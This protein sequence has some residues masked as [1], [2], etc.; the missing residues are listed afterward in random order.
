MKQMGKRLLAGAVAL[1]VV[2]GCAFG[3]WKVYQ[4][5]H[6]GVVN[7]YSMEELVTTNWGDETQTEGVVSTDK[8]QTEFLS[9]TQKVEKIQVKKGQKVK[10]GD[11]LFTYDSTLSAIDLK[12]KQIELQKKQ[13]E[14][15]EA[16]KQLK[17]I[18]TYRAGVPI[19]GSKHS[20]SGGG[21]GSSRRKSRKD[22]K[23]EI[24]TYEGL[25][26]VTGNGKEKTPFSYLWKDGFQF[27]DDLLAAAMRDKVD[28][29]VRFYLGGDDI[30][31]PDPDDLNPD[32]QPDPESDDQKP[33]D[34]DKDKD[35]E[36]DTDPKEDDSGAEEPKQEEPK[37]E[38]PKQGDASDPDAPS[39]EPESQSDESRDNAPEASQLAA[40]VTV[41]TLQQLTMSVPGEEEE[42]DPAD[43]SEV[44]PGEGAGSS[45][46]G[47]ASGSASETDP[48]DQ[49]EVDPGEG[50]A[51]S[52]SGSASGSGSQAD[53]ADGELSY[54]ASWT[55][56][57][58]HTVNGYRYVM[59][60]MNVG[61]V[62]R[63]VSEPLPKMTKEENPEKQKS[64]DAWDDF[65]GGDDGGDPG[66]I[67][68]AAEIEAM[69]REQQTILRDGDL[70]LRQ[71]KLE[72]QKLDRELNNSAVYSSLNGVVTELND[73][74]NL[75]SGTPLLKVSSGGGYLVKGTISELALTSVKPGQ[76]VTINDWNTDQTYEGTVKQISEYPSPQG[77]YWSGGNS[78]VSYYPFTVTVDESANLEPNGYVEMSYNS[79]GTGSSNFYLQNS[80]IRTENGKSYVYV[81]NSGKLEKRFVKTGKALWGS[82]TEITGG[83]EEGML[84]AFPYGQNVR[85]NAPT[86]EASLE[87][88]YGGY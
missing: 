20:G 68:T 73:P 83:L 44:D 81:D 8:L 23:P 29:Y 33:E 47:S 19:P 9:E 38:E 7:V 56:H 42:T 69:R 25:V 87:S 46:S 80:F 11:V 31:I 85:E 50:A 64:D 10:K 82:Y 77:S 76:V 62:E 3:G 58:Q 13:L 74:K 17:V 26:L 36:K 45:A 84:L 51:S 5:Y 66:I 67:Y 14:V 28:A 72:E 27:T 70:A 16:A 39:E 65:W 21:G 59:V 15:D 41:P 61:G 24:P 2:G 12:R 32:P 43:Q 71:L 52:A 53:P 34:Q 78:N 49:S 1:G 22:P 40:S 55:M 48:A 88:L 60:S 6:G 75:E 79:A 54:S 30:V 18:N 4:N 63:K 86:Q 57:C 35:T 37:Q